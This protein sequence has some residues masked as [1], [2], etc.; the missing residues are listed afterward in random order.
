MT[1]DK[2]WA[3]VKGLPDTAKAQVP[4]VLATSTKKKLERKTPHE[5]TEIVQRAVAE[6][7]HGSIEP[8][9]TLIRKCL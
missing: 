5:V 4:L 9:D 6:V 8:L 1:F 7:D 2:I 3:Q